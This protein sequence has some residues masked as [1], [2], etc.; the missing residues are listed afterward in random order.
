MNRAAYEK[1]R[2]VGEY[3]SYYETGQ[4]REK[5]TYNK[6]GKLEGEYLLYYR[7]GQLKE[8]E[9]FQDGKFEGE[10]VSYY[11]NGQVQGKGEFPQRQTGR[12]LCRL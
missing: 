6:D 5:E 10:Y 1:D 4:L 12:A 8:K 9:N 3:R 7:N 2:L 11:K